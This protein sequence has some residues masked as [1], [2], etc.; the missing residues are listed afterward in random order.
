MEQGE[1]PR[2]APSDSEWR[3]A[4][5]QGVPPPG[6]G[7]FSAATGALCTLVCLG[8]VL[9]KSMPWIRCCWIMKSRRKIRPE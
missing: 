1:E 4:C 6:G 8:I 3:H 9:M 5:C 7:L 2:A